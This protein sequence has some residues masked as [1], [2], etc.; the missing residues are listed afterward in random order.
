[1]DGGGRVVAAS[2][3]DETDSGVCVSGL[4]VVDP[5]EELS[6]VEAQLN[7][8]NAAAPLMAIWRTFED[9]RWSGTSR[10]STAP[11]GGLI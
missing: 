3:A 11:L 6:E 2:G 1:M 7:R 4:G 8:S 10:Q 5:P 9:R